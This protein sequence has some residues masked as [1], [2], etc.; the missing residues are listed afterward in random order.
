MCI[1]AGYNGV[2]L[3]PLANFWL[4]IQVSEVTGFLG[5][6]GGGF[7]KSFKI[8]FKSHWRPVDIFIGYEGCIHTALAII[9]F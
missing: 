9:L 3:C 1:L 5:G 6:L 8:S 4:P 7:E 2:P